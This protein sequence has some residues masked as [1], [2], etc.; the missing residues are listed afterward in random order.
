MKLRLSE[1]NKKQH[2][3]GKSKEIKTNQEQILGVRR[4]LLFNCEFANRDKQKLVRCK[5]KKTEL[6]SAVDEKIYKV[7]QEE[8]TGC[9]N[10]YKA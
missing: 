8:E 4:D 7:K 2:T 10:L 5:R 1:E 6:N 9:I 3:E